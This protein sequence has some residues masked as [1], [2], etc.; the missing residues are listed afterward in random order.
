MFVPS[1]VIKSSQSKCTE[2]QM[3]NYNLFANYNAEILA[4]GLSN[5][6]YKD[7]YKDTISLLKKMLKSSINNIANCQ[8]ALALCKEIGNTDKELVLLEKDT[9]YYTTQF[10]I[11]KID[12]DTFSLK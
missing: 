2:I 4:N 8:T 10:T 9:Q 1:K 3:N 5:D 6:I 11:A 7:K 12:C